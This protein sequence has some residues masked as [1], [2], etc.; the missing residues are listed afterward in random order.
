MTDA[1]EPL[2]AARAALI[3]GDLAAEIGTPV[4]WGEV[5][6]LHAVI[7]GLLAEFH[8]RELH[9]FESEKAME[10]ALAALEPVNGIRAVVNAQGILRAATR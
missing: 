10:E 8:T 6:A 9:H 5:R 1:T 4:T 7:R 2:Q 3:E